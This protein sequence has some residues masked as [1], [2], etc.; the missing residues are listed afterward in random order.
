MTTS[1]NYLQY[2]EHKKSQVRILKQK[3]MELFWFIIIITWNI[4]I[5]VWWYENVGINLLNM[6]NFLFPDNVSS[7]GSSC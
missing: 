6:R 1:E 4:W 7:A 2:L 5:S 3:E